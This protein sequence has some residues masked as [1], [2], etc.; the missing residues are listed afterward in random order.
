MMRGTSI[1]STSAQ[2]WA[3]S[4]ALRPLLAVISQSSADSMALFSVS[5]FYTGK[6]LAGS[7]KHS[8]ASRVKRADE[9]LPAVRSGLR[10]AQRSHFLTTQAVQCNVMHSNAPFQ[11]QSPP[12]LAPLLKHALA[13]IP[14]LPAVVDD[15]GNGVLTTCH[16]LL[17]HS[18]QQRGGRLDREQLAVLLKSF[19]FQPRTSKSTLTNTN[20]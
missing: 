13:S 20:E 19:A 17:P 3:S 12:F 14:C 18:I 10:R 4:H 5:H 2:Q 7:Q 9:S 11:S 16:E 15:V 8:A 1:T 6:Q